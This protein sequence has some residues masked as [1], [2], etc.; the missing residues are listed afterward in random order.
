M[1]LVC[2]LSLRGLNVGCRVLYCL[3]IRS[4]LT[5]YSSR[6]RLQSPPPPKLFS[7]DELLTKVCG[8]EILDAA[9]IEKHLAFGQSV[10]ENVKFHLKGFLASADETTL[11]KLLRFVTGTESF[12]YVGEEGDDNNTV[13][14]EQTVSGRLPSG[15]T[16]FRILTLPD[17]ENYDTFE[18]SLN[19]AIEEKSFSLE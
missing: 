3:P 4:Y 15:Q 14:V 7:P 6:V 17:E 2:Y 12:G 8:L 18:K 1:L 11:R 19:M 16:C 10:G 9:T 13:T 5:I